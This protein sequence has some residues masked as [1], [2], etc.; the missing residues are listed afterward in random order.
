[1]KKRNYNA[2]QTEHQEFINRHELLEKI[3]PIVENTLMRYG[4]LPVEVDLAKENHRWFLRIFIYSPDKSVT[5]DDCENIS[6]SMS[7]FLD[8][9]IPFKFNLEI[10][11]PG[12]ERKIKS[13]REYLI[14]KGKDI[15][16][17]LKTPIDDDPET[18]QIV[19]KIVDFD[20]NEGLKVY[21]YKDK[22]EHLVEKSQ[23]ISARLY[24]SEI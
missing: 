10:S 17:K 5:L 8:E 4:F 21:L 6:R 3:M 11:S 20:E 22:Q 15:L 16:L 14:F 7:D 19:A 13:D 2:P 1:M 24:S 23:I 12:I 9:L 18:T